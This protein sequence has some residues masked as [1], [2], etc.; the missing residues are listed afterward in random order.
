MK[1]KSYLLSTIVASI[2]LTGCNNNINKKEEANCIT[3][4]PIDNR[5][6]VDNLEDIQI[7]NLNIKNKDDIVNSI[8]NYIN[9]LN[10]EDNDGN[11]YSYTN[12]K[13]HSD[14][15]YI[16]F[17][18]V[19]KT[20]FNEEIKK[21]TKVPVDF[22]NYP[23]IKLNGS[24][25]LSLNIGDDYNEPGATATDVE[26]G[27]LE[28]K[29][30]GLVQTFEPGV[31]VINYTAVD[32]DGNVSQKSRTIKVAGGSD[33][34][35]LPKYYLSSCEDYYNAGYTEN[36]LYIIDID[37]ENNPY[38]PF[39]VYCDMVSEDGIWTRIINDKTTLDYL[40]N[41]GNTNNISNSFYKNEKGIG[42]GKNGKIDTFALNRI[43]FNQIKVKINAP[44]N[45]P[46]NG[47]GI[48]MFLEESD[49]TESDQN[50][51]SDFD[52][53]KEYV[54]GI[55]SRDIS[56]IAD[57]GQNLKINGLTAFQKEQ[58][59]IT[60]DDGFIFSNGNLKFIKM[61]NNNEEIPYTKR[62]ISEMWVRNTDLE[63]YKEKQMEECFGKFYNELSLNNY[64]NTTGKYFGN[65]NLENKNLSSFELGKCF[66]SLT[67]VFEN[68]EIGDLNLGNNKL[69]E[70]RGLNNLVSVNGDL[71]LNRNN[72]VRINGLNNL[73]SVGK[74]LELQN[75][76]ITTITGLNNI[77]T[78]NEELNLSNNKLTNISGFNKLE[79]LNTLYLYNNDL[80]DIIGFNNLTQINNID[81]SHN[82]L[83]KVPNFMSN[84]NNLNG[85]LY[86]SNNN[87]TDLSNLS[88][89]NSISNTFN[90]SNNPNLSDIT[91]LHNLQNVNYN[92][93]FVNLPK[94]TDITPLE[95]LKVSGGGIV[96]LDKKEY[97][98]K[99]PYDSIFCE[100][101]FGGSYSDTYADKLDVCEEIPNYRTNGTFKSCKEIHQYNKEDPSGLYT[102]DED[103]PDNPTI[104]P[105]SVY[106]DMETAGGGWTACLYLQSDHSNNDCANKSGEWLYIDTIN[107]RK[108]YTNGNTYTFPG[109]GAYVYENVNLTYLQNGQSLNLN[110]SSIC[111]S[112]NMD[113]QLKK[114]IFS[115]AVAGKAKD[116]NFNY[117]TIT[118]D[119]T[120]EVQPLD[121]YAGGSSNTSGE[122][123]Y[124]FNNNV[125][126][127]NPPQNPRNDGDILLYR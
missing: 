36:G 41:F 126:L 104:S 4:K 39:N 115:F 9:K 116:D 33:H 35:N 120:L 77:K 127:Q 46:E 3:D 29:I 1:L 73:I 74:N 7:V 5:Q 121:Q 55:E 60:K 107:N 66:H 88:N 122:R 64:D 51:N 72:I 44:Y 21:V 101:K 6:S 103:G 117:C 8:Q 48:L 15:G 111:L 81:I 14:Q 68:N 84:I 85:F 79:Y 31:Y 16:L 71:K 30:S 24:N 59:D 105:H 70:L 25:S 98:T 50:Q 10:N 26:D 65:I 123:Y 54:S 90:L 83:T 80:E 125:W 119:Q 93:Y 2:V 38:K 28:V 37:G 17:T 97:E 56:E 102:I 110:N 22:T 108:F 82:K 75:N 53:N 27:N 34:T 99:L 124:D 67:G 87:I 12:F 86:L 23:Q 32:H 61:G 118:N 95:N 20:K 109:L 106:C 113:N 52:I 76:K 92:L 94:L 96:Y 43:P 62:Y 42:W 45:N 57:D 91:P 63:Q 78:I 100:N 11:K 47:N 114:G 13:D 58:K 89:L 112:P 69:V 19:R 40:S 18:L 49:N